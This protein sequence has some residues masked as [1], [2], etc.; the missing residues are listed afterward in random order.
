MRRTLDEVERIVLTRQGLPSGLALAVNS[1]FP[2]IVGLDHDED[3]IE[4][5]GEVSYLVI[6]VYD[7]EI[8]SRYV[9]IFNRP[10][11]KTLQ[12]APQISKRSPA[13]GRQG[14]LERNNTC[15][16]RAEASLG[17][18]RSFVGYSRIRLNR[19]AHKQQVCH[20]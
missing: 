4:F 5:S 17:A 16:L 1:N 2:L 19:L 12:V 20:S 15:H 8:W 18:L 11:N 10:S 9:N 6:D 14:A 3:L 7:G 13:A